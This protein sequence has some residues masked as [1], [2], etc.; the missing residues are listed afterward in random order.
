MTVSEYSRAL[1]ALEVLSNIPDDELERN[2]T[3]VLAVFQSLQLRIE[4]QRSSGVSAGQTPESSSDTHSVSRGKHDLEASSSSGSS[5]ASSPNQEHLSS[6]LAGGPIASSPQ[7]TQ[8]PSA[9]QAYSNV[10]ELT[11]SIV[12]NLED[13]YQFI[14]T[15]V[16]QESNLDSSL[17]DIDIRIIDILVAGGHSTDNFGQ[18]RRGLGQRSLACEFQDWEVSKN[19]SSTVTERA[20]DPNCR[21]CEGRMIEYLRA[22]GPL[23]AGIHVETLRNALRHGVK[24][25]VC[26][27]VLGGAGYS[28]LLIFRYTQFKN[29]RYKDLAELDSA[30]RSQQD[31]NKVSREAADWL[32]EWQSVYDGKLP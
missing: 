17:D 25:L 22:K 9:P 15:K 24:L 12:K 18:L 14:S 32:V 11:R 10:Q 2:T 19:Y 20:E 21:R 7:E 30:F 3:K 28:A 29:L 26:E 6:A 1:E 23:L 27:K 31:I 4:R 8:K 16:P 5:S 13:I